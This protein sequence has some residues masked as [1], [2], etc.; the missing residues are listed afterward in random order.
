MEQSLEYIEK[1]SFRK[2]LIFIS[3][4]II[5]SVMYQ[6]YFY[7][8]STPGTP[9]GPGWQRLV[10][11]VIGISIFYLSIFKLF[12][13]RA[14]LSNIALKVPLLFIAAVTIFSLPFIQGDYLQALN[15]CF[16]IPLLA[17]NFTGQRGQIL[18]KEI[19]SMLL[20]LFVIQIILDPVLKIITG[21]S[22]QNLAMY[23]GVGNA[24][25]FGYLILSCAIFL[26]NTE[27]K[28]G[29]FYFLCISSFFTGSLIIAFA[30]S[31]L[32]AISFFMNIRRYNVIDWVSFTIFSTLFLVIL[33]FIFNDNFEELF[34]SVTHALAKLE[35]LINYLAG[36]SEGSASVSIREEYIMNGFKMLAENP[37]GL[38]FGH[39]NG[40]VMYT[41]DGWW[42]ALLVTHGL[43]VTILF[44]IT[45][46]IIFIRGINSGTQL[47]KTASYIILFTC[48]IFVA[49]RILDYWPAGFIYILAVGFI[50]NTSS[51]KQHIK[52]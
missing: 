43:V 30:S 2:V 39:P 32:L 51:N 29:L 24:N 33:S 28:K 10:L 5:T 47:G 16:F 48:F 49:N 22:Y 37:L 40:I 9:A 1:T 38:I 26:L 41:G 23:G 13:V 12:S 17:I 31:A 8:Y 35:G 52:S 34:R 20:L 7:G 18:F 45:N 46:T 4:L 19:L 11:K 14:F 21:I 15:L 50:C 27:N 25:S 44:L 6:I 36:S 42:L 3:L